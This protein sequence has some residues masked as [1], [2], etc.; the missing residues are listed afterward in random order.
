MGA[1]QVSGL[2]DLLHIAV[3]SV[4]TAGQEVHNTAGHGLVHILHVD[5]DSLAVAQV[6][7]GL[8]GVVEAAGTEQD[9]LLLVG[10]VHIQNLTAEAAADS[11]AG[12]NSGHG[13]EAKIILFLLHHRCGSRS[14]GTALFTAGRSFS[15][16]FVIVEVIVI[17]V[18]IIVIIICIGLGKFLYIIPKAHFCISS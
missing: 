9:D 18:V 4:N 6:I 11:V 12:R 7:S 2:G 15:G 16:L 10:I 13:S 17:L 3:Q 14:G 8:G 5:D 1:E